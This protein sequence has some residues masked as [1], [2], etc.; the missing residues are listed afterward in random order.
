MIMEKILVDPFYLH[1][2]LAS[3]AFVMFAVGL[4]VIVDVCNCIKDFFKKTDKV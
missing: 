2:L 1:I 3:V 4:Y